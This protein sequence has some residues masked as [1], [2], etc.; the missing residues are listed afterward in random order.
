MTCAEYVVELSRGTKG[1]GCL[2]AKIRRI[3]CLG[4]PKSP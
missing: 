1:G 3:V 4:H 2:G